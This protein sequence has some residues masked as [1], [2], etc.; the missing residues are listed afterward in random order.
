ML[1]TRFESNFGGAGS[2]LDFFWQLEGYSYGAH[3]YQA[4][5]FHQAEKIKLYQSRWVEVWAAAN[6]YKVIVQPM[7]SFLKAR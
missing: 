7:L 4:K 2:F 3:F 1:E 5:K 6:I